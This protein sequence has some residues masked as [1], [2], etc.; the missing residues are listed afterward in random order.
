MNWQFIVL[1]VAAAI[2][3]VIVTC[4]VLMFLGF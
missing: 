2:P 4:L 1:I 3:I